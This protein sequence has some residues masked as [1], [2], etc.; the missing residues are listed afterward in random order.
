[1]VAYV[2]VGTPN[3]PQTETWPIVV[4]PE[5]GGHGTNLTLDEVKARRNA[6]AAMG[7]ET[8]CPDCLRAMERECLLIGAVESLSADP[9]MI[10]EGRRKMACETAQGLIA[11]IYKDRPIESAERFRKIASTAY[12]Q[13]RGPST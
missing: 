1:M 12:W 7:E 9:V 5:C 2:P 3:G 8:G 11:K 6:L 10:G 4:C 13:Q